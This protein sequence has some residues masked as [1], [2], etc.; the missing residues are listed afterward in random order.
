MQDL[1]SQ[2]AALQAVLEAERAARQQA[3]AQLQA[4]RQEHQAYISLVTHELRVPMTAIKG[5]ADLLIKGIMGPVSD[6][7]RSAMQTIRNNVERMAHMVSDLNEI[8]KLEAHRLILNLA[9]ISVGDCIRNAVNGLSNRFTEKSHTVVI[10]LP[11]DLPVVNFDP[12]RLEQI[13]SKLLENTLQYS[14]EGSTTTITAKIAAH[15]VQIAVVDTGY[16]ILED[17]QKRISE[18]FFRASDE[19]T[20]ATPGNG[21]SLHLCQRL[22][23]EMQGT[24]SF[25]SVRGKGSTFTITLPLVN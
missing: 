11:D 9:P 7:Q 13:M 19:E 18:M 22:L 3:E 20:R 17:E 6:M 15:T 23:T 2:V 14:P 1:K 12:A 8:N 4:E 10:N 21:L 25:T 24:I 5:Y 16:G